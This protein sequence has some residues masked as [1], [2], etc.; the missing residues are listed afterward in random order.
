MRAREK[1]SRSVVTH[2]IAWKTFSARRRRRYSS[3]FVR[4]PCIQY[5][6]RAHAGSRARINRDKLPIRADEL[7]RSTCHTSTAIFG[8][9]RI[10][11][12]PPFDSNYKQFI[13]SPLPPLAAVGRLDTYF[14][15][16]RH[17]YHL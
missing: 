2:D 17:L 8:R 5:A 14:S 11:L 16:T 7:R 1:T 12:A 9:C 4:H 3:G 15:V 10:V 6:K 13:L